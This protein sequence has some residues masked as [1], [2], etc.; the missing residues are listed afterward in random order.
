MITAVTLHGI[1]GLGFGLRHRV[2]ALILVVCI[3]LLEAVAV[4]WMH[5]LWSAAAVLIW[6]L[7]A[8]QVGYFSGLLVR[9]L[10]LTSP[11][12]AG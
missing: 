1:A 8:L 9:A 5:T 10:V 2:P 4:A 3:V 12:E 11:G 7:L 6:G